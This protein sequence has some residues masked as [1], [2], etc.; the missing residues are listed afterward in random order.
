MIV[1]YCTNVVSISFHFTYCF[2]ATGLHV[3]KYLIYDV[4]YIHSKDLYC[5]CSSDHVIGVIKEHQTMGGKR[6]THS[7]YN[8]IYHNQLHVKLCYNEKNEVLCS[9]SSNR[10]IYGWTVDGNS[11]LFN[12]SR[13]SDLITDFVSCED[14]GCF[15]TCSM[16]K[17]IVLWSASTRRVKGIFLGHKR[18]IRHIHYSKQ[19]LISAAFETE[20]RIW[21]M[22]TKDCAVILRGHRN[23]LTNAILMN[24]R[25]RDYE[26][27]RFAAIL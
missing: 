24:D 1:I 23:L 26:E 7:I 22:N 9:V 21:D 11:P 19:L 20:A 13:H 17:R 10:V 6:S 8:K 27:Y 14:L 5:Y 16:D 4:I 18:G 2:I 25:A 12:I 3:K 15:A